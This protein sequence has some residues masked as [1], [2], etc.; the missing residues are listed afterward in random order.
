MLSTMQR[1]PKGRR[2]PASSLVRLGTASPRLRNR[3]F[4]NTNR[5]EDVLAIDAHLSLLFGP[6]TAQSVHAAF[7]I[8]TDASA[9]AVI[10]AAR[11]AVGCFFDVKSSPL[12]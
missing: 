12:A 1:P 7:R 5:W 6:W 10:R 11:S 8:F 3:S 9:S 2:A 4:L